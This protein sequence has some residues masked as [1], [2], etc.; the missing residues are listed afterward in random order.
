M[1]R[2]ERQVL[3]GLR[4]PGLVRVL[5][6]LLD[7]GRLLRAA[8]AVGVAYPGMRLQSQKRERIVADLAD[9]ALREDGP[10][11]SLVRLLRKQTAAEVRPWAALPVA[12]RLAR[13]DGDP[14]GLDLF[15]AASADPEPAVDE[16]LA[17]RVAAFEPAAPP[18]TEPPAPAN[19]PE[20]PDREASRLR[21]KTTELQKKLRHLDGQIAKGRE[22]EKSLKRDLIQRKGELAEA[23]MLAERLRRELDDAK[24]AQA[25]APRVGAAVVDPRLEEIDRAIKRLAADQRKVAHRIEKLAEAPPPAPPTLDP[26]ALEPALAQLADVAKEL[27]SLR[28]ERRKDLQ[29]LGRRMDEIAASLAAVREAAEASP[30]P[31]RTA[32]RRKGE[33]ERV[34]VFVDVQNMY[35]AAR[36]LKGKLDF[37]AL[38][39]AAVLDRRLIQATAYVV[40][41][42]EIDQSGFIAMLEQRAIEV[43]RKALQVRADGST[44]GDWDME[45]ALDILD[46]APK[47]DV[48]A[49]VSGDGDFT[50]LVKRVKGLGPKVEVLAFPRATAKSLI[51]AAD[52]YT[53]LDRRFMI[54]SDLP[55]TPDLAETVAAAKS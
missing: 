31:T 43:R 46:M 50:A 38:L 39:A 14:S 4:R 49:L 10:G 33:P 28:R 17:A 45:I 52:R 55:P 32:S 30:R 40:E 37:D 8:N 44:K 18:S 34:G 1:P 25:T 12:D 22:V 36:Q 35:Y 29:D 2:S 3:E 9:K 47:L 42:K 16:V 7:Q 26:A 21:K 5:D 48:V 23:R 53:P 13:L 15:L 6:A 24:G 41:T 11:R 20:S 54:R 27:G 19:G 51:E